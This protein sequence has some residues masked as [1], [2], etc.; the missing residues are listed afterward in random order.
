ML[1]FFARHVAREGGGRWS[2]SRAANALARWAHRA[3]AN[4]RRGS[5]RN[6]REHYDLGNDFYALFLD[7][8][9]TY[10]CGV[11]EHPGATMREASI[12]KLDRICRKLELAGGQ[13]VLEI[14][15]GWGGFALHAAGRYGCHVTTTTI[16]EAQR[17]EAGRR[18][19]AAGLADR[20]HLLGVDYRDLGGAY[21]RVVSIE[22]IEAVGG[23]N[24]PAFFAKC[25]A[26]LKEDGA[27]A[28]QAITMPD[29]DWASY[30]RAPDFIQRYVFPGSCVP[31]LG[32]MLAAAGRTDLRVVDV[33]SLGP[34]YA[35]TLR[36]WRARFLS[37][38]DEVRAQGR[39][40][41]FLRLWDYY[42][43]YCE[44]GFEERY[45]DDLQLVWG[46]PAWRG[47]VERTPGRLEAAAPARA[48]FGD[49]HAT[50]R[51]TGGGA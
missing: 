10:S 3:R 22:M 5:R 7:D 13:R 35:E 14:G 47:A 34:H 23:A 49:P 36:R 18:F 15:T 8:T 17:T 24:L 19:A 31:S 30:L 40:E 32:A 26:L 2:S 48:S 27:M 16:S 50:S 37:R 25:A 1:G 9:L 38:L 33:E 6:I 44:A 41:R 46:R 20:I 12:A 42:L 45:V 11:F 21:D 51:S 29:R 28:V 39:S 4:T 43:S